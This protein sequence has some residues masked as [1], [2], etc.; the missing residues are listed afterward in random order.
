M[1]WGSLREA[2][3]LPLREFKDKKE[4]EI[5]FLVQDVGRKIEAPEWLREDV[6]RFL[7]RVREK[8]SSIQ[9]F[10]A[11]RRAG[12][13]KL[14]DWKFVLA[15]YY[16][17]SKN[18]GLYDLAESI[19]NM[20]CED[21][22][23]CYRSK[24]LKDRHFYRYM[25]ALEDIYRILNQET[26]DHGKEI[27]EIIRRICQKLRL[28]PAVLGKAIEKSRRLANDLDGSH[29]RN[30]AVASILIGVHVVHGPDEVKKTRKRMVKELGIAES[31]IRA[32]IQRVPIELF[33]VVYCIFYRLVPASAQ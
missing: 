22:V 26:D 14:H 3:S 19:G 27:E 17:L 31:S 7:R 10:L 25:V 29:P 12:A 9:A 4:R 11:T 23:P 16:V 21:E 13:I 20:K 1:E 2:D 30:I 18:R 15:T 33:E 8:R 5:Y 28:P 24:K 32:V 6:F